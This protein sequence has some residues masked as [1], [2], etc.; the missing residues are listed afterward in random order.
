M[1]TKVFSLQEIM[2]PCKLPQLQGVP[3]RLESRNQIVKQTSKQQL[4]P[5][6]E[7]KGKGTVEF[8]C[9]QVAKLYKLFLILFL[10]IYVTNLAIKVCV[11]QRHKLASASTQSDQP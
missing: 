9:E 3:S 1:N 4:E 5:L 7:R 11:L 2:L 8:D 10:S 6:T